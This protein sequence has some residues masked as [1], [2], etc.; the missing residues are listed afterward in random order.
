MGT[1]LPVRQYFR[2]DH[3]LHKG[4]R[5]EDAHGVSCLPCHD[6]FIPDQKQSVIFRQES[7]AYTQWY[8]APA[9][10]ACKIPSN[11][12]I[13]VLLGQEARY[14]HTIEAISDILSGYGDEGDHRDLAE[15]TDEF[16]GLA[17]P[18][19]IMGILCCGHSGSKHGIL[20]VRM[21]I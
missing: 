17:H 3:R 13:L 10:G 7:F 19:H 9:V 11:S 1:I 15:T 6:L 8:C 12:A 21:L 2:T 18:L 14:A 4:S 16:L 5:Q 20:L